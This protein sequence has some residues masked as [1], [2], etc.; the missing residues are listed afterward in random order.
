M[1]HAGEAHHVSISSPTL[2]TNML[3]DVAD[4]RHDDVTQLG[5]LCTEYIAFAVPTNSPLSSPVDLLDALSSATPP[6]ISL[7]TAWGN[8]NHIAVTYLCKHLGIHPK[9][10]QV[11][12]FD[13]ARHAI[14]DALGSPEGIAAVSAA[15]VV[16]EVSAGS[17]Q[18]L[19]TSAPE[20][21][22]DPLE[23]IQTWT[24]LGI[25]CVIGTWRGLVGPPELSTDLVSWWDTNMAKAVATD[26]WREAL[27]TYNWTDSFLTSAPTQGFMRTEETRM[28]DALRSLCDSGGPAA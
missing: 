22:G 18:V 20:R 23:S 16:P 14:A 15:S 24:E 12:V 10:V 4:L 21:L 25:D 8:V 26:T 28:R 7:A 3:N 6:T 2:I 5:L 11:R 17:I 1:T 9:E 19:A 13:S 27:V